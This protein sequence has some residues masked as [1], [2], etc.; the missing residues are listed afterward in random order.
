MNK[1][2]VMSINNDFNLNFGIK[3]FAEIKDKNGKII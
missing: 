2:E 3:G 1:I